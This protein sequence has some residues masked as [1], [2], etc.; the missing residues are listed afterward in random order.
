MYRYCMII[1]DLPLI[2]TA[3]GHVD[4]IDVVYLTAFFFIA[5]N[6]TL[7]C[8]IDVVNDVELK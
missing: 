8:L 1:Y 7:H 3:F 2:L 4:L 5:S 6:M